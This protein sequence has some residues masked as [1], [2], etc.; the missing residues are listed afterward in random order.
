MRRTKTPRREESR[1]FTLVELLVVIGIIAVLISVLLP[2]LSR[3]R[4]Q[5]ARVQCMNT[6][7]QLAVANVQYANDWKEWYVPAWQ[8]RSGAPGTEDA[9]SSKVW[10]WTQ[11]LTF[12]KL[13]IGDTPPNMTNASARRVSRNFICPLAESA[14]QFADPSADPARPYDIADSYGYNVSDLTTSGLVTAP[15]GSKYDMKE[16]GG[17]DPSYVW[18]FRGIRRTW[19]RRPAE[20]LQFAD[21]VHYQISGNNSGSY[22]GMPNAAPPIPPIGEMSQNVAGST[23]KN[24]CAFRHDR[25]LNVA[26][27]DGHCEYMKYG[28]V[29]QPVTALDPAGTS[30]SPNKVPQYIQRLWWLINYR[31]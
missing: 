8:R 9:D 21:A 12:R 14:I 31:G 18:R 19:L 23:K 13:S 17:A 26:F 5:A 10:I 4:R 16:G 7:R 27:F 25:G 28:D 1:G 2:A 6:M 11:N 24:A 22:F 3:A 29:V 15:D 30:T 20:K